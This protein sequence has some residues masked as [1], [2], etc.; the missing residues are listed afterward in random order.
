ML[1][2]ESLFT[3][4]VLIIILPAIP[5]FL[6][7]K[8]LPS[9]AD[10]SGPFHGLEIKLGGAFAGYFLLVVL[11]IAE[12]PRI[13]NVVDPETSQ[14]W[15]VEGQLVDEQGKG[16]A[17]APCDIQFMPPPY[18]GAQSGWFRATFTTELWNKDM[19][20]FPS[21]SV[22]HSG[23]PNAVIPLN[24][25]KRDEK[26][27]WIKLNP[28]VF[29]KPSGDYKPT[30]QSPKLADPSVYSSATLQASGGKP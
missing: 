16:L 5:A 23:Y 13:T 2:H 14:I 10:V 20:D 12:L 21:L 17:I 26:I 15:R 6:L 22:S 4:L 9:R 24:Y 7:F 25:E 11:I 30:G 3:I 29:K 19:V 8:A 28:I 1:Q 18:Q 27:H